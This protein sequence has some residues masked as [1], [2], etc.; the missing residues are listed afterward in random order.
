MENFPRVYK[1]D[2]LKYTLD[3]RAKKAI[4]RPVLQEQFEKKAQFK[5]KYG[6]NYRK[7]KLLGIFGVKHIRLSEKKVKIVF[8]S[9]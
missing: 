6:R 9:I 7:N 3:Y 8:D 5:G 2:N 4:N 1:F